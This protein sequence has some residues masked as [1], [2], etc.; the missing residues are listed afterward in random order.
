MGGSEGSEAEGEMTDVFLT[1]CATPDDPIRWHLFM[2]VKERWLMEPG[3]NLYVVSNSHEKCP[4]RSF[5]GW[6]R[7]VAEDTAQSPIYLCCDDDCMPMGKDFVKRGLLGMATHTFGTFPVLGAML[8]GSD[9]RAAGYRIHGEEIALGSTAGGVNFI[10][11]GVLRDILPTTKDAPLFDESSQG[12]ALRAAGYQTGYMLDPMV[13][14][15]GASI[16]TLWPEPFTA[17][18]QI[19]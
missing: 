17:R 10:R 15:L 11:K 5:D 12:N 8:Y 6:R 18:T 9:L 16:S 13:N 7:R 14:H 4:P 1:T 3:I 2:A 19:A